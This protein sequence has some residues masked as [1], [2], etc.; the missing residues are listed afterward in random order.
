MCL[1][2]CECVS[3]SPTIGLD[4]MTAVTKKIEGEEEEERYSLKGT[5]SFSDLAPTCVCVCVCVC[6]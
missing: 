6:L 2:V 3:V 1:Y 5:H 4:R